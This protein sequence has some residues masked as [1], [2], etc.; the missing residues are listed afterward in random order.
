[1]TP[2]PPRLPPFPTRR[3][4]DLRLMQLFAS[5]RETFRKAVHAAVETGLVQPLRG[6]R[7]CRDG[8]G[9]H[10]RDRNG[11]HLKRQSST[12]RSHVADRSEEHTSEL[13]SLAYLVCRL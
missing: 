4:S 2:T 3:S 1:C 13:Q 6:M 12:A 9:R 7:N 8:Q 5:F 11:Q 10:A